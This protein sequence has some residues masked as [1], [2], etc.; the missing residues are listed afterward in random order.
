[1]DLDLSNVANA[2]FLEYL[3]LSNTGISDLSE[4]GNAQWLVALYITECN[5]SGKI[6]SGIFNLKYLQ[7]LYANFNPFTSTIPASIGRLTNLQELYMYKTQL[8]GK[9]PTQIG[10]L[11]KLQVLALSDNYMTGTIPTELSNLSNLRVLAL[12]KEPSDFYYDG[13]TFTG[14]LPSFS[15]FT[16]LTE[17][18]LSYNSFTGKIPSSFLKS[19]PLDQIINVDLSYNLLTGTISS[20]LGRLSYLNIYLTGNR[21]TGIN[22]T[23][24]SSNTNW[25][26]GAVELYG[27]DAILCPAKYCAPEGRNT[28]SDE[29]TECDW[30]FMGGTSKLAG[31]SQKEI[32][33]KLY[34]DTNGPS[35]FVKKGEVKWTSTNN[36]CKWFG[37]TCDDN[38]D[39][40]AIEL[41]NRTLSGYVGTDLF[42][43]RQLNFLN[44][45]NNLIKFDFQG[46]SSA[47]NLEYLYLHSCGL[48]A[49]KNIN[50]L[51]SVPLKELSLNANK[52]QMTIP[53]VIYSIK[54][55]EAIWVGITCIPLYNFMKFELSMC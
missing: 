14:R 50:E 49:L 30:D 7:G 27:C 26:N 55:L 24:C 53:S 54:S 4:I 9:I 52:L 12:Q 33:E 22:P 18:Y 47:V 20:S 15:T 42:S 2:N 16:S 13:T 43:L 29:C 37:I 46:I 25:M 39:V 44:L 21:I 41:E 5:L 8:S 36:E 11:T 31:L 10:L 28:D 1:M 40:T 48:T 19:A 38:G 35:W 51:A 17:L 45:G 23:I 32:L 6:P 34:S 3:S